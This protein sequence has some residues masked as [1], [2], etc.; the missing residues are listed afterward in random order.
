MK[1][2]FLILLL[3]ANCKFLSA[4]IWQEWT[5]QKKTQIKYLLQQV[6][7]NEVY[8]KDIE[9]GYSIA[10]D[11]L[12]S[13]QNIK[14]GDFN[15]H[16]DYF[17]SLKNV[18]PQLK[19][20]AK[21]ADI[22]AFQLHIIKITKQAIPDITAA[23]QFTADELRYCQSVFDN[24]INECSRNIDELVMI[25]TDG[26]VEMKDDE[27]MQRIDKL[28]ESMQDKYSFASS[29]TDQMGILSAERLSEQTE[30]NLS[31]RINGETP[32]P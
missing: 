26:T 15:L 7:A 27:R 19:E 1:R 12:Q 30:I 18:N 21:V 4:Q 16:A 22:V 13:I 24:L 3:I 17:Q 14:R 6:A 11:G 23:G 20:W 25:I 5:Q 31:K 29:F 28:Y 32:N 8:I 2:I 10:K 9:K